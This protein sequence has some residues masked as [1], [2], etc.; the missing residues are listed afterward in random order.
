A[1]AESSRVAVPARTTSPAAFGAARAGT[2]KH[3]AT[4]PTWPLPIARLS[5][6]G[7]THFGIESGPNL[8]CTVHPGWKRAMNWLERLWALPFGTS[9]WR[10]LGDHPIPPVPVSPSRIEPPPAP[11]KVGRTFGLDAG[12][13]LPITRE[14]IKQAARGRNLLGN[15]WFGR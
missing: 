7:T 1:T 6:P 13:Y 9:A 14:E 8:R 4:R 15:L 10:G 5:R 2:C 12:D 11:K 3:S